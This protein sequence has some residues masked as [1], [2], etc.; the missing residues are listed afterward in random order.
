ASPAPSS[1]SVSS[2]RRLRDAGSASQC[3]CS[4]CR[5]CLSAR[6]GATSI[7]SPRPAPATTRTGRRSAISEGQMQEALQ[8]VLAAAPPL[9]NPTGIPAPLLELMA[10]DLIPFD[11]TP[12]GLY[13]VNL[14]G[15][16]VANAPAAGFPARLLRYVVDGTDAA[17]LTHIKISPGWSASSG[18]A[19]SQARSIRWQIYDHWDAMSP[20]VLLR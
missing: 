1:A 20:S 13:G 8:R 19:D 12:R 5:R 10:R 9:G 16:A 7:A 18:D 3:R 2:A 17:A 6:P 14:A 11:G 15:L 4:R